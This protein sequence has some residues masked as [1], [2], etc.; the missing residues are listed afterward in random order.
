MEL[1]RSGEKSPEQVVHYGVL[2][3]LREFAHETLPYLLRDVMNKV[4]EGR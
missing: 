2:G 4:K 3:V 1:L